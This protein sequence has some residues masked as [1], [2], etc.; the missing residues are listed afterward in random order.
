V[1]A[2]DGVTFFA[3]AWAV[4]LAP[5]T[6]SGA[7]STEQ[8]SVRALAA[9]V[10]A[11]LAYVRGKSDIRSILILI[12][13]STLAYSG[14]F[15]VGLPA[16]A[17]A[18]GRG[19]LPLGILVASWGAGQLAGAVSATVTGLPSRWGLL[20]VGMSV[21]EGLSFLVIGWTSSLPIACALFVV[22]GFGVA[23]ASDVA[24]PTW[25][26]VSTAAPILG[27]VTSIMNLPR[28]LLPPVSMAVIGALA[29]VS[30]RL[31][32]FFA[33]APML[34]AGAALTIAGAT[35]QLAMKA[36]ASEQPAAE[37]RS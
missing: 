26:Q 16:F 14:L 13:A 24:I 4:T 21:C 8:W 5:R 28:V 1:F 30:V 10:R 37:G 23:Y 35:R 20:L 19:A 33:A 18:L 2:L 15:A 29:V 27:R 9:S 11:G 25:I 7:G 31:P 36:Q 34:A 32:F 22:L 12:A 6:T 17:H 3:A